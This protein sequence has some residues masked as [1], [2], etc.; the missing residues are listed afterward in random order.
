M[1]R[2]ARTQ[3]G[4]LF[5]HSYLVAWPFLF[6]E[7]LVVSVALFCKVNGVIAVAVNCLQAVFLGI[8]VPQ[9][10][11]GYRYGLTTARRTCLSRALR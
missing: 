1:Q 6:D 10:L 4:T 7:Y 9:T 5:F 8:F 2:P 11:D 3:R